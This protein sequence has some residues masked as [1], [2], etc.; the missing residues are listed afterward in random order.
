MI[1]LFLCEFTINLLVVLWIYFK[2]SRFSRIYFGITI[3]YTNWLYLNFE[4]TI[5]FVNKIWFK[6]FFCKLTINLP[7]LSWYHQD[8]T[9]YFAN[10]LWIYY[11]FHD[12]TINSLAV[13]RLYNKF[14]IFFAS[15]LSI[16]YRIAN[17]LWI[18]LQ[19]HDY[20]KSHYLFRENAMNLLSVSQ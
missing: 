16:N 18:P 10:S 3:L 19:F 8:F 7:F 4:F 15:S 20:I 17:L 12:S 11:L 13:S 14:W 1:S 5:H 6:Y 9:W 2:F